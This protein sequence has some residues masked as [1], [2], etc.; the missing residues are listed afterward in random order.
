MLSFISE[1]N[2]KYIYSVLYKDMK[3]SRNFDLTNVGNKDMFKIEWVSKKYF[4]HIKKYSVLYK[5]ISKAFLYSIIF[6]RIL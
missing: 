4:H 5:K 6:H 1:K 3:T 2:K